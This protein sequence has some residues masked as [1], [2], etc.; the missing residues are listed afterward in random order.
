MFIKEIKKRN[1]H[2]EKEF[3]SHR[4]VESYRSE[5]GPRHRTILNLGQLTIPKEQWKALADTIEAKLSG[6]QNLYPIEE[7]I[8]ALADHYAQLIIKNRMSQTVDEADSSV[9]EKKQAPRYVFLLTKH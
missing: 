3:Y 5:K 7:D 2:Y 8:E 6:Q 4:L 1:K 9:S